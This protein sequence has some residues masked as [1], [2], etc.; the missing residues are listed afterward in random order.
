MN[1]SV[2]PGPLFAPHSAL[3]DYTAA[4]AA[5]AAGDGPLPVWTGGRGDLLDGI[6]LA[7]QVYAYFYAA[8]NPRTPASCS[9]P[10]SCR[11]RC[12]PCSPRWPATG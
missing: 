9:A 4:V 8:R 10:T 7:E 1:A 6:A 5:D 11:R 2:A 12:A 3:D